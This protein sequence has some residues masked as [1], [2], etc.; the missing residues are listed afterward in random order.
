MLPPFLSHIIEAGTVGMAGVDVI[1][2]TKG[3][4]TIQGLFPE[5]DAGKY[6]KNHTTMIVSRGIS[7]SIIPVRLNNRSE[8]VIAEL[9]CD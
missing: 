5:F 9:I 3:S 6:S 1:Q 4:E 2:L 8:I 7:N